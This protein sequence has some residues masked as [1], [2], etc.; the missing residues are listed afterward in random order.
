MY[1]SIYCQRC[2]TFYII[3]LMLHK[4]FYL[5]R[6]ISINP[7]FWISLRFPFKFHISKRQ[8]NSTSFI[9]KQQKRQQQNLH[10]CTGYITNKIHVS[11]SFLNPRQLEF[12]H[13]LLQQLTRVQQFTQCEVDRSRNFLKHTILSCSKHN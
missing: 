6:Y 3:D 5:T 10:S 1:L 4:I 12:N 11:P 13:S 8:Q 9:V 7:Q 2:Q